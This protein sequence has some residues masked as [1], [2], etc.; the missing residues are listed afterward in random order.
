M[1]R[2]YL[3]ILIAYLKENLRAIDL[4]KRNFH[5]LQIQVKLKRLKSLLQ[6]QKVLHHLKAATH[7]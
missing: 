5:Q 6:L 3:I 7:I 4:L 2:N 1:E